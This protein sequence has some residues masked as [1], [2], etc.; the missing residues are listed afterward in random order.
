M[1]KTS[2]PN[3]SAH[4]NL[5]GTTMTKLTKAQLAAEIEALRAQLNTQHEI[6][7]RLNSDIA[8]ARELIKRAQ[9]SPNLIKAAPVKVAAPYV[10]PAWQRERAAKL[11]EAKELAMSL[12]VM[13]KVR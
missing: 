13:T 8:T 6:N 7:R 10:P 2:K 3:P 9:P 11:A 12:G 5:K 4:S 1:S